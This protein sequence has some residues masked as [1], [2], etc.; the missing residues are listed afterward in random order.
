MD[1]NYE[2]TT[3]EI[4]EYAEWLG[5]DKDQDQDLL[6]IAKEG[7]KAPLPNPWKPCQ[8]QEGEIF[9][10]NFETG[11]SVWDHPCDDHYRK[12]FAEEK[13]KRA[14]ASARQQD[15]KEKEKKEKKSKKRKSV[16]GDLAVVQ[17]TPRA[18][19][20]TTSTT[21][22]S[23]SR[24]SKK[25]DATSALLADAIATPRLSP[26]LELSEADKKFSQREQEFRE[27]E[28]KMEQE[29]K[30][31]KR[32]RERELEKDMKKE[33]DAKVSEMQERVRKDVSA[34]RAAFEEKQK[35]E[36]ESWMEGLRK[37]HETEKEAAT[38]GLR[39]EREQAIEESRRKLLSDDAAAAAA[40]KKLNAEEQEE[41]SQQ[42]KV[43]MEGEL[44]RRVKEIKEKSERDV[45][46]ARERAEVEARENFG[47]KMRVLET[48]LRE[49]KRQALGEAE[50]LS[51]RQ[52]AALEERIRRLQNSSSEQAEYA[53]SSF[54]KQIKDLEKKLEAAETEVK[55]TKMALA[56]AGAPAGDAGIS[57]SSPAAEVEDKTERQ[58]IVGELE[59]RIAFLDDLVQRNAEALKERDLKLQNAEKDV[60][61][62]RTRH[63]DATTRID[64][65]DL[66]RV[67][68]EQELES[69]KASLVFERNEAALKRGENEREFADMRRKLIEER[70]KAA[71]ERERA[72]ALLSEGEG[73]RRELEEKERTASEAALRK[74][75][76]AEKDMLAEKLRAAESSLAG[77]RA[78]LLESQLREKNAV[79]DKRAFE[80]ET[81][82]KLQELKG[83]L[84]DSERKIAEVQTEAAEK[85]QLVL[86]KSSAIAEKEAAGAEF[87][88]QI[89]ALQEKLKEATLLQHALASASP[90]AQV[91]VVER[92]T[93]ARADA[94]A[95]TT[96][97]RPAAVA[98]IAGHEVSGP[99]SSHE[100]L[101]T[102]ETIMEHQPAAAGAHAL[103]NHSPNPASSESSAGVRFFDEGQDRSE[104]IALKDDNTRLKQKLA[105]MEL[106]LRE[107]KLL[108]QKEQNENAQTATRKEFDFAA[109][110]RALVES[111]EGEKLKLADE[112]AAATDEADALREEITF[113]EQKLKDQRGKITVLE[114][115]SSL[116]ASPNSPAPPLVETELGEQ[117]AARENY[118]KMMYGTPTGEVGEEMSR[119]SKLEASASP[120]YSSERKMFQKQ[121][122]SNG[123]ST[124]AAANA[125]L[126]A[127]LA[128]AEATIKK[129]ESEAEG[130]ENTI[131]EF[132][133]EL[134][135]VRATAEA[136]LDS[137]RTDLS[138]ANRRASE[139]SAELRTVQGKLRAE[140]EKREKLEQQEQAQQVPLTARTAATSD[141]EPAAPMAG[142]LGAKVEDENDRRQAQQDADKIR[143][144]MAEA[145]AAEK[146]QSDLEQKCQQ[147]QQHLQMAEEKFA[148]ERLALQ[149]LVA[150][151][152]AGL[153]NEVA[154]LKEKLASAEQKVVEQR[155]VFEQE[156]KR[157]EESDKKVRE[158]E[159][160]LQKSDSEEAQK[161]A[162]E[163]SKLREAKLQIETD[164]RAQ[165]VELRADAEAKAK[166]SEELRA[167]VDDLEATALQAA[168]AAAVSEKAIEQGESPPAPPAALGSQPVAMQLQTE[169]LKQK[170][171]TA[172]RDQ[173]AKK[174]EAAR[175]EAAK[176]EAQLFDALE[177]RAQLQTQ[178]HE[179]R[180][181][182]QSL[183]DKFDAALRKE[184]A[185][186]ATKFLALQEEHGEKMN[187][188]RDKIAVAKRDTE[189]EVDRSQYAKELVDLRVKCANLETALETVRIEADRTKRELAEADSKIRRLKDELQ[190]L[191]RQKKDEFTVARRE[192]ESV[193]A[194]E[195]S[196]CETLKIEYSTEKQVLEEAFQEKANEVRRLEQ[197]LA[198][199]IRERE[200]TIKD[201]KLEVAMLNELKAVEAAPAEPRGLSAEDLV[202]SVDRHPLSPRS[203]VP[204]A[205]E[206]VTTHYRAEPKSE[207][208]LEDSFVQANDPQ[209]LATKKHALG[210]KLS[211]VTKAQNL[212]VAQLRS[213]KKIRAILEK[214][215]EQWRRD[216]MQSKN[217]VE[218]EGE[219][220]DKGDTVDEER[221]LLSKVKKS[222]DERASKLNE[223]AR[224]AKRSA[225]ALAEKRDRLV[226]E[227]RELGGVTTTAPTVPDLGAAAEIGD[228]RNPTPSE[229]SLDA[230]YDVRGGGAGAG[231]H[232]EIKTE[233]CYFAGAP[234]STG[235]SGLPLA[236]RSAPITSSASFPSQEQRFVPQADASPMRLQASLDLW[237]ANRKSMKE[238]LGKHAE[239]MY[240]VAKEAKALKHRSWSARGPPAGGAR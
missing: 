73:Q 108:L 33:L 149:A 94:V 127:A 47:D 193:L 209:V 214:D 9:Y 68:K 62:W 228:S 141:A 205:S 90:I 234:G 236:L 17:P 187:T 106:D 65:L 3:Q 75:S 126:K 66:S 185:S 189:D 121:E 124:I 125:T 103:L 21:S 191:E 238:R 34:E 206:S 183:R 216:W 169:L 39:R 158:L 110:K 190:E 57:A 138:E 98:L 119:A 143:S 184:K 150:E 222:L 61:L 76:E 70:E 59:A 154:G 130:L 165:L 44:L 114:K 26:S 240:G 134:E 20:A 89:A 131:L 198:D 172:E 132:R 15:E 201:L 2:P 192:H 36:M 235:S 199:K 144:L 178:V 239:W 49:E 69:V 146:T 200:M 24:G 55:E 139:S 129:Q 100:T 232:K 203:A 4:N 51:K 166:E 147:A 13:K 18:V 6:W 84:L 217:N 176:K 43:E 48:K 120:I 202:R 173:L 195:R 181:G 163:V 224:S 38:A 88:Q 231:G 225:N 83:Q 104:I 96:S 188:M 60:E 148:M 207:I 164:L 46:D 81:R 11:E 145:E 227:L 80:E 67:R 10:F 133:S 113:L 208:A 82:E 112:V 194:V 159:A 135:Q 211:E 157:L 77:E 95:G 92:P 221:K 102:D 72:A 50:A 122:A 16:A 123:D 137:L 99:Q 40:Q 152:R 223:D 109:E 7:L 177:E 230:N 182:A 153:E 116:P 31:R 170:K 179:L 12:V 27:R 162:G 186:A 87:E 161:L 212:V 58:Q 28:L 168:A 64:E 85:A 22:R 37:Q 5:M 180:E 151:E 25:D 35:K 42:A 197:L 23:L 8:T 93:T 53:K 97:A 54:E 14:A 101:Q 156:T 233:A 63:K 218:R 19:A 175:A 41:K 117:D 226:W 140:V 215:R 237:A 107:Q 204:P 171:V 167:K 196:K 71:A 91:D 52:L 86:E 1:E 56:S 174:L 160:R 155:G 45:R 32:E 105:D 118:L 220:A 74:Q 79:E 29:F 213:L 219:G 115:S 136:Q 229:Q 210:K 78:R 142:G 111:L 30:K 128:T